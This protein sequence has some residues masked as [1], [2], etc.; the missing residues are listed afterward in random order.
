MLGLL[1][2]VN[3]WTKESTTSTTVLTTSSVNSS[4]PTS[5][6]VTEARELTI[7]IN[8]GIDTIEINSV[9]VDPGAVA[10]YGESPVTVIADVTDL[11]VTKLGVYEIVY[12]AEAGELVK[13]TIRMVTVLDETPP[14]VTL[15]EGVDTIREGS[16]WIDAG[17]TVDDNSLGE[18]AIVTEGQVSCEVAGEYLIKYI[19]TDSS[20][21]VTEMV[22]YINVLRT[23]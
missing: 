13:E 7:Q 20:G 5:T 2:C 18:V 21:N 4:S 14:V 17:I 22:R 8:P 9:Y 10:F 19:V 1:S 16:S 15:N 23:P 6:T 11:D 3:L 12:R